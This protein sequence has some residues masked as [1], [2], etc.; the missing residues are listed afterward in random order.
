MKKVNKTTT[1]PKASG[2][3]N[4]SRPYRRLQTYVAYQS[5]NDDHNSNVNESDLALIR[6]RARDLYSNTPAIRNAIAE[7][8]DFAVSDAWLLKSTA[9]T[10]VGV[11]VPPTAHHWLPTPITWVAPTPIQSYS[12]PL[13]VL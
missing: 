2:M 10:K 3:Y 11:A 9:K 8:A 6:S 7:I 12:I 1:K 5:Y 4:S 13:G